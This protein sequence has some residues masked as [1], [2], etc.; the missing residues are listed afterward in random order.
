MT[1]VVSISLYTYL[2][3]N[4]SYSSYILIVI[5]KASDHQVISTLYD[6]FV[7]DIHNFSVNLKKRICCVMISV[8]VRGFEPQS[9]KTKDYDTGICCFSPQHAS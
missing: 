3:L 4:T 2:N 9:G 6:R 5:H 1:G 7:N 8:L